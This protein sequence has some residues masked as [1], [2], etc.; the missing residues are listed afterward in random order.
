MMRRPLRAL[1]DGEAGGDGQAAGVGA[2]RAVDDAG[3]EREAQVLAETLD[4]AGDRDRGAG[5]D[6]QLDG[7]RGVLGAVEVQRGADM[8]GELA[9]AVLQRGARGGPSNTTPA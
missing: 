3:L 8:V 7:L 2:F 1:G 9:R 5:D 4:E 6:A